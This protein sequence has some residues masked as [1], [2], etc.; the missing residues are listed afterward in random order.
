MSS[1]H[2]HQIGHFHSAVEAARKLLA[3]KPC[4]TEENCR[5]VIGDLFRLAEVALIYEP[6]RLRLGEIIEAGKASALGE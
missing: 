6:E 5:D 2:L 4:F 3:T 1:G